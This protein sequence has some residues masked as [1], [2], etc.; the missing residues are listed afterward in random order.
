MKLIVLAVQL[1]VLCAFSTTT[2]LAADSIS[3]GA[4]IPL[5]YSFDS[6]T[7]GGALQSSGASGLLVNMTLPAI[8]TLGFES[9][10]V[11]LANNGDAKLSLLIIDYIYI[12]PLPFID[13]GVGVGAGTANIKGG[14][15]ATE[16]QGATAA[17]WL[18]QLGVPLLPGVS[19]DYSYHSVTARPKYTGK[20][21]YLEGS[22]T[23]SSLGISFG[24]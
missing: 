11:A 4:Q 20:D 9:Y 14:T 16:Y 10:D 19:L 24:F 15:Y 1:A 17:Q 5:S 13:L 3:I 22:G 6:A 21:V 12:F 8:G 7:D 2:L 18:L 23:M